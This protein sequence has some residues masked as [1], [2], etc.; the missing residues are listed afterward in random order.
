MAIYVRGAMRRTKLIIGGRVIALAV[1]FTLAQGG[2]AL[3]TKQPV[4][5][6]DATGGAHWGCRN[7]TQTN[8]YDAVLLNRVPREAWIAHASNQME[9]VMISG[10]LQDKNVVVFGAGGSI[11]AAVAKEFALEGAQVFLAG[12]T[13]SNVES[14]ANHIAATGGR[15]EVA[16]LDA[17]DDIAVNEYLDRLISQAG[18]IDTVFNATGPLARQYGNGK[19][20]VN[21]A[22]E[23]FMLPLAAVV[24]SQFITARAAARHMVTQHSGVIIF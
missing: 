4:Q 9:I 8:K 20:A 11:G 13:Q 23:E 10:I 5:Q 3:S 19:Y 12:R 22:I 7:T 15:A 14:V 6:I 2:A 21:L 18:R 17:L 16:A 24:K 1:Q